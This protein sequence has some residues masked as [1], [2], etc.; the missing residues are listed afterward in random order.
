LIVAVYICAAGQSQ[1]YT[2]PSGKYKLT[3]L[4]DWRPISYSDAVGRARTEFVYRDRSEGLLR[5]TRESLG[6]RSLGAIVQDEEENSR[7]SRSGFEVSAKEAFGGGSLRGMRLS[8]YY[9]ESGRRMAATHYYLEDGDSVWMLKFI[10][11]R[12][13]IDTTRNITDQI[14][15]SFR[16]L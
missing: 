12:G 15:R 16:S 6:G 10:G 9:V 5:I 7:M 13:A 3:L 14:A 11:R 1:E 4:A 2:D 8:F